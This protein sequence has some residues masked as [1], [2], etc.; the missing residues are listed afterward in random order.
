[1]QPE[2]SE[3]TGYSL[4]TTQRC[5]YYLEKYGF[6]ETHAALDGRANI[7]VVNG[8]LIGLDKAN[9]RF[10]KVIYFKDNRIKG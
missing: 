7:Y 2:I 1:V 10:Y 4:S 6:I 3:N 9:S 5:I 8:M